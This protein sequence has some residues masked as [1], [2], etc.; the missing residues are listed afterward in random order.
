MLKKY[1]ER[2]EEVG[3]RQA[4]RM[5]RQPIDW[6]ALFGL[7]RLWNPLTH[8]FLTSSSKLTILLEEVSVLLVTLQA[9]SS[10]YSCDAYLLPVAV[11]GSFS[12]LKRN[13]GSVTI[14][15]DLVLDR[16]INLAFLWK[17]FSK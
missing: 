7:Y 16:C 17:F 14:P 8:T 3:L 9:D 4:L 13:F 11:V 12:L 10:I 1:G 2:L 6:K 15:K 5:L